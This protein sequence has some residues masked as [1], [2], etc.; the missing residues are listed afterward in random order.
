MT[1]PIQRVL[2]AERDAA[3]D[4]EAARSRGEEAVAAAR[5][6]AQAIL[7]RNETRTRRAVEAFERSSERATHAETLELRSAARKA[8]LCHQGAVD[9]RLDELVEESFRAYW[10]GC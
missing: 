1:H 8:S 9:A 10:P 3:H 4:I 7:A 6:Q 2:E 5:R